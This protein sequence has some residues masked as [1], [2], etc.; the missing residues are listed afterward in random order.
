MKWLNPFTLMTFVLAIFTGC[1]SSKYTMV[2]QVE[3]IPL[4]D[5]LLWKIEGNGLEQ[6]S[7]LFGTMHRINSENFF[8]PNGMEEAISK[9]DKM[10]FEIDMDK[11]S[12]PLYILSALPKFLMK[13]DTTISMLLNKEEYEEVAPILSQYKKIPFIERIKPLFLLE[14]IQSLSDRSSHVKNMSYEKELYKYAKEYHMKS[15]GL[16]TIKQQVSFFDSIPYREQ[17]LNIVQY[18]REGSDE[19]SGVLEKCY[20]QQKIDT[21]W[22][23]LHAEMPENS[24]MSKVILSHRNRN[25]IPKM[26][27]FMREGPVLF[28]VGAGHLAGNNGL[29]PLLNARGYTITPLSSTS[30]PNKKR[31]K[32]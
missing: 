4:A 29:L 10:V 3:A 11:M 6:P 14:I 7:Y 12:N 2:E 22:T 15:E 1:S 9:A 30:Y 23:I 16:E 8:W 19:D 31:T 24:R 13:N 27:R 18:V 17:A 25:W 32:I 26:E 21:L 5:A 20:A 28:A